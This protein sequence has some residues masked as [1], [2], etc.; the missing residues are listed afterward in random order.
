MIGICLVPKQRASGGISERRVQKLCEGNRIPGV[1]KLGSM[2][3][4]P[5]F[6]PKPVDAR[7]KKRGDKVDTDSN[8]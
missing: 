1:A 4:L 8:M 5:K 3:L 2:W 6:A 7:W